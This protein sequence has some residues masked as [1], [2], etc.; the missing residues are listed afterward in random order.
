V[1]SYAWEDLHVGLAADFEVLVD[2]AMMDRFLAITG[3][4][5]PLHLDATYAMG[6]GFR[7]RVV[8]G[9]LTASFYST[10]AGVHLPGE[11]CLLH[12]VKA[13]FN[14]PVYVGDRLRVRGTVAHLSEAYRQVELACDIA[15][16]RAEIVSKARLRCGLDPR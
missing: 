9:L 6:R 2:D 1:K 16:Q 10:L 14:A 12:G 8:Y 5:N 13:D 11:R 3:D 7:S 4:A 15:N